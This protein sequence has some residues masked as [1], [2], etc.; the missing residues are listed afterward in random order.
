MTVKEVIAELLTF[1]EDASVY[2][3]DVSDGTL[4]VVQEI[5]TLQH[6]PPPPGS[7]TGT[8][9]GVSIPD[10]VVMVPGGMLTLTRTDDEDDE[11]VGV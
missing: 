9:E 8:P 6:L 1:P 7:S 4:Q 5:S 11:E 3:P 10:D 2:V